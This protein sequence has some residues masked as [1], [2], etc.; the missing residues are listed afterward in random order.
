MAR[1]N[2]APGV[3]SFAVMTPWTPGARSGGSAIAIV[4]LMAA[5]AADLDDAMERLGLGSIHPGCISLRDLCGIDHGLVIRWNEQTAQLTTH[6]GTVVL[7]RL[8]EA[9]SAAGLMQA[10]R[11]TLDPRAAYPEARDAIEACILD[12]LSHAPSPLAVDLLLHQPALWRD[13]GG[14]ADPALDRMRDRLLLPPTVVAVGR[15]N[16]GKSTLVNALARRQ[17]AIV[18]PEAGTTRD[19]LGV[20][21]ELDGLV[22]RWVDTP[23]IRPDDE[24]GDELESAAARLAASIIA[25]ADLVVLCADRAH[26]GI[27]PGSL[28][29]AAGAHIL[30]CATRSDL[31]RPSGVVDIATAAASGEGLSDLARLIR[32]TLVPDEALEST[33]PWRFHPG[34]P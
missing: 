17:V 25:A 20:M 29:V 6:G 19:H 18:S 28:G 10:D 30:R 21:L 34:L 15:A 5:C 16:V 13:P 11:A 27:D 8:I 12:A 31:G 7:R 22:V 3:V 14:P 32:R 26:G 1:V 9:L 33:I 2:I 24:P 4:Q 23:G